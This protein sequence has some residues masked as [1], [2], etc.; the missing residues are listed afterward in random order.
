MMTFRAINFVNPIGKC[1]CKHLT[2]LMASPYRMLKL[3]IAMVLIRSEL[4]T[5][6]ASREA[7]TFVVV[8]SRF[9]PLDHHLNALLI[10]AS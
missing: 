3:H 2:P 8:K 7:N 1:K 10:F 9:N 5:L 6:K 4:L